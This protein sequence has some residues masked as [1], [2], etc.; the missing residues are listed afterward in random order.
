MSNLSVV[1]QQEVLGRIFKVYGTVENPL[2]L[3]KDVAKWIGYDGRTGQLLKSVDEEEKLTHTIHASGQ[4]RQMWFLT[5]DGIYEVLMLSRKPIAKQWKKEVKKILKNIRLN[6]GH[7]QIDREEE[8]INNNFSSFSEEL[9]QMMV[10]D[11]RAKNKQLQAEVEAK[12][13]ILVEQAPKMEEHRVFQDKKGSLN[14]TEIYNK[15][16]E[17]NQKPDFIRGA[18]SLNEF[19]KR[20][21]IQYK[22]GNHWKLYT[23]Y[24]WLLD[25][26]YAI[27]IKQEAATFMQ[28]QLRWTPKGYDYIVSL[29]EEEVARLEAYSKFL[30]V[31]K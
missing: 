6:G 28:N 7:V 30:K 25:E 27:E 24:K 23:E 22:Q 12:E 14:P 3:A 15:L 9:K 10:H 18:R 13:A 21:G 20:R 31:V 5:E 17:L 1:H 16:R 2:F 29:L 26:G 4:V 11:L 8:F 19:L